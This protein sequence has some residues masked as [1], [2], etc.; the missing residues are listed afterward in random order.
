MQVALKNFKEKLVNFLRSYRIS[1]PANAVYL[2]ICVILT[3]IHISG[4]FIWGDQHLNDFS[5]YYYAAKELF[6]N[7]LH[8]YDEAYLAATYNVYVFRYFPAMLGIIFYPLTALPLIPAYA[9]FTVMSYFLNLANIYLAIGIIRKFAKGFNQKV[10]EIFAATMLVL[11]FW[12]D[13]YVSG[14]ISCLLVFVLL[15]SLRFYLN[16][17]E[18]WGSLLLGLSLVIKPIT[19]FQIIFILVSTL[20]AKNVK[21]T[22]KRGILI[23]LPLIPDALLFLAV[24]GLLDGFLRVNF[25]GSSPAYFSVSFSNFFVALLKIDFMGVFIACLGG[26]I[27]VGILMLRKIKDPQQQILFS[28]V[29]GIFGYFLTQT[30]IWTNQLPLLF[31]FLLIAAGFLPRF[32][33][34]KR[35]FALY[36][37]YPAAAE[38]FNLYFTYGNDA[39]IPFIPIV[40]WSLFLMVG[41]Y[42]LTVYQIN[43]SDLPITSTI[44]SIKDAT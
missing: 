35:Y 7:P 12:I 17:R 9:L 20:L 41:Y 13:F 32:V 1:T 42:I 25:G 43:R 37:I 2:I 34:Q 15:L 33:D 40:S 44:D 36:V 18:V 8:I 38:F 21:T 4:N 6:Q 24:P 14:Q 29:F 22:I 19:F 26:S 39:I 16:G 31:P 27:T 28:F 30:D 23:M 3:S 5:S 11:P 10:I